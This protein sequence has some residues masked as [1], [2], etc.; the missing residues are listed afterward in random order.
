MTGVVNL[1][2]TDDVD[3]VGVSSAGELKLTMNERRGLLW[4]K[5]A[6]Q[7]LFSGC[8]FP[9]SLFSCLG[10]LFSP[11]QFP[12]FPKRSLVHKSIK[13]TQNASVELRSRTYCLDIVGHLGIFYWC[14]NIAVSR[15]LLRGDPF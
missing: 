15:P 13:Q 6:S 1:D 7:Y 9:W 4:I 12:S 8:R 11:A 3:F 10:E 2:R 5:Q 14:Q